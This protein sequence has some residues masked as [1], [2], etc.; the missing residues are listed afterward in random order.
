MIYLPR[1]SPL[2]IRGEDHELAPD[3]M[4]AVNSGAQVR[5]PRPT[6]I[7]PNAENEAA[8]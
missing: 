5:N 8:F 7:A 2:L 4:P 3:L 1:H 6:A